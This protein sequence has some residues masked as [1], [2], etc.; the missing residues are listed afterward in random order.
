MHLLKPREYTDTPVVPEVA[1][2]T[3]AIAV[4]TTSTE[5]HVPESV[6]A[7]VTVNPVGELVAKKSVASTVDG[8]VVLQGTAIVVDVGLANIF[9]TVA[10]AHST[11]PS[12]A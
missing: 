3:A 7:V 1:G 10:S 11:P 4:G 12:A 6:K 8:P 9:F 5:A 2:G